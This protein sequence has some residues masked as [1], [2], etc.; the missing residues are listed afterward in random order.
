ML[1]MRVRAFAALE[2]GRASVASPN[3]ECT[4]VSLLADA[5]SACSWVKDLL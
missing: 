5:E 3:S 4:G 2:M 1:S